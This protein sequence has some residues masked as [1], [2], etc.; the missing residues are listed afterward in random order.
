MQILESTW[1][2]VQNTDFTKICIRIHFR[3]SIFRIWCKPLVLFWNLPVTHVS[4]KIVRNLL[5]DCRFQI[6]AQADS[7]LDGNLRFGRVLLQA[8]SRF[9]VPKRGQIAKKN[10]ESSLL[11]G[12]DRIEIWVCFH[13]VP[14]LSYLTRVAKHA[15][16]MSVR[17]GC[18]RNSRNGRLRYCA[19]RAGAYTVP[20]V[21]YSLNLETRVR[22][23]PPRARP[24]SAVGDCPHGSPRRVHHEKCDGK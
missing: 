24:L 13:R 2:N 9:R 20:F 23:P 11:Q 14:V 8:D 5:T 3:S 17:G 6:P 12:G 1:R 4:I 21:I 7:S 18:D 22:R 16:G 19:H 15:R 10:L